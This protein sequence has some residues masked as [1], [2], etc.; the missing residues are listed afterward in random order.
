M[1]KL[2]PAH[3]PVVG[4]ATGSLPFF[5]LY[6]MNI[7]GDRRCFQVCDDKET[8]DGHGHGH[9]RVSKAEVGDRTPEGPAQCPNIR[10]GKDSI[11]EYGNRVSKTPNSFDAD[12]DVPEIF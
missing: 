3:S 4:L 11:V 2:D 5:I 10:S 1:M 9:A 12:S 6:W 8:G 7:Y